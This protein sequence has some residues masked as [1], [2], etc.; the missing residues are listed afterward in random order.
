M[1]GCEAAE[2]VDPEGP[3]QAGDFVEHLAEAVRAEELMLFLLELPTEGVVFGGPSRTAAL[4][5][6]RAFPPDGLGLTVLPALYGTRRAVRAPPR[7]S[8]K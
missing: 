4:R 7:C 5:R 1:R 3:L 8:R 2:V 6:C